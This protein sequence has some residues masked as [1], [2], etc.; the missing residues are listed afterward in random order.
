MTGTVTGY[1]PATG[2]VS[3]E[4]VT[5]STAGG[6]GPFSD[7]ALAAY[8]EWLTDSGPVAIP[9]WQFMGAARTQNGLDTPKYIFADPVAHGQYY[10]AWSGSGFGISSRS[11]I[12]LVGQKI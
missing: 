3:F 5:S 10:T 1:N 12:G 8:G 11:G 4:V 9:V 2:Q 6:T 7:W